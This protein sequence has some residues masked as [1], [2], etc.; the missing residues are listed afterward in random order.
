MLNLGTVNCLLPSL[1]ITETGLISSEMGV[2]DVE[3]FELFP[4][5]EHILPVIA[6][7]WVDFRAL[8]TLYRA[9]NDSDTLRL[10]RDMIR[11][12]NPSLSNYSPGFAVVMTMEDVEIDFHSHLDVSFTSTVLWPFLQHHFPS[13]VTLG[14]LPHVP[15]M[16]VPFSLA[17]TQQ[18]SCTL[19]VRSLS[20]LCNSYSMDERAVGNKGEG[21]VKRPIER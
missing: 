8:T 13:P 2:A 15:T 19:L 12:I 18:T 9:T 5:V 21:D 10:V 7:L 4:Q 6:P 17:G 16:Q 14:L 11:S 20:V 1:Q 3:D